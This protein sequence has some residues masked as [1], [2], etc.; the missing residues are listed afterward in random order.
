M[1]TD[2][3]AVAYARQL[4]TSRGRQLREAADLTRS[5]VAAT[6]PGTPRA[7]D[8]T[9]WEAGTIRPQAKNALAYAAILLELEQLT[10]A[11]DS[12]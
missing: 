1:P 11:K 4:I 7:A 5:S 12:E 2:V 3:V 6:L 8:I 9:G 10:A